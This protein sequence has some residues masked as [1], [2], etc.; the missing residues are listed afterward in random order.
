VLVVVAWTPTIWALPTVDTW[1]LVINIITFLLV[2]KLQ[3]TQSR[4]NRASQRKLDAIADAPTN[5]PPPA[6]PR[7]V[8][9][10]VIPRSAGTPSS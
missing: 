7:R 6:S 5:V 2:A 9:D 8:A 3:N 4:S 1:Q 10:A